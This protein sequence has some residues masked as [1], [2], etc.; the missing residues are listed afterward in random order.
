MMSPPEFPTTYTKVLL[1]ARFFHPLLTLLAS[2][3]RSHLAKQIQYLKAEN[4]ILRSKLPK[5]ITVTPKER[6]KLLRYGKPLGTALKQLITIVSP[7]TFARWVSGEHAVKQGK[8]ESARKPG[9]PKTDAEIRELV[10]QLAKNNGWGY[11][12]I[13]GEL[14]KLGIHRLCRT[15]VINILKEAGLPIG[16]DRGAGS[17]DEFLK[18]HAQTLWACD[19]ITKKIWTKFGLTEYYILFFI[20]VGSRRAYISGMTDHPDAD[21]MAQ[22]ARNVSLYMTEQTPPADSTLVLLR[23]GDKKFAPQFDE[24]LK[25]GGIRPQRITF[26]SPNLNAY[27]ERFAQ[28]LQKECLDHFVVL[29]E[30]HLRHLVSEF[31]IHFNTERPHQAMGNIPLIKPPDESPP[32]GKIVCQER[33]GGLLRHYYRQVA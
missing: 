31:Q 26:R 5:R 24:I 17:W 23:D 22:Q 14:K 10:I 11:T 15:T 3:T 16:P 30:K 25:A 1:V 20:H 2:V 12:R 4:E 9:R 6:Q 7:R 21:W 29:G 28:T 8:P 18:I 27:A 33:L 19:F 13:L 32:E